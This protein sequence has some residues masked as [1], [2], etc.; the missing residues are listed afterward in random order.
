MYRKQMGFT[1]G[2]FARLCGVKKHTL[3]HYD[4]IGIFSP[5]LRGENGY[6]YYAP[7]QIEVFNVIAALKKLGV[8]LAEIRS[9]LDRRSPEELVALLDRE[10]AALTQKLARLGHIRRL[11]GR[12]AELTRRAMVLT[13]GRVE[14]EEQPDRWYV[15]TPADGLTDQEKFARVMARHL[16][17]CAA[18][19]VDSPYA[20]GA[21]MP[22]AAA[23]RGDWDGYTSCYTQVDRPTQGVELFTAPAGRY[24]TYC[25]AGS[26]DTVRE[27]YVRLL[28]R[29]DKQRLRLG[30]WV[31]EDVLLDE[32][33]CKGYDQYLLK[34]S[35]PV[36]DGI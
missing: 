29:A 8:P 25:H 15:V 21:L 36:L 30:P 31:L 24:L 34:L 20:L 19:G 17:Y 28:A 12:K 6:R 26:F 10:Q 9:Y 16:D 27:G 1:T 5:A 23:R 11:M 13:P 18:H 33:C 7:A 32:L 22:T 35:V 2:E 4:E 14:L 3:F